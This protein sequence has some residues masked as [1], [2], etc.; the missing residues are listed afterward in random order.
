MQNGPSYNSS[1][2]MKPEKSARAQSRCSVSICRAA[3]SPP[4]LDPVLDRGG[5]D[6]HAVI[7]PEG[8]FGPARGQ[9]VLDDQSEGEIDHPAGVMAA[10]VSPGG[11]IGVEVLAATGAVV[12]G[13]E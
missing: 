7:A 5:G 10:G 13:V 2:A 1:T 6:E 9:A 11:H 4:G 8:P 3:G 12:L